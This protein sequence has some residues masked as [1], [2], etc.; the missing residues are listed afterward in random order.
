MIAVLIT[1]TFDRDTHSR[2]HMKTHREGSHRC[3][4]VGI[5]RRTQLCGSLGL[6]L[7]A[8]SRVGEYVAVVLDTV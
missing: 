1:R 2:D 7:L 5:L 3:A 8:P 4:K 6:R